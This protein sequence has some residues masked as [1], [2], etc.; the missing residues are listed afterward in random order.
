[1]KRVSDNK[2]WNMGIVQ[3]HV[4][5][6]LIPLIK[7]K[8][9]RNGTKIMLKLNCVGIGRHKSWTFMNLK[10]PFLIRG[11]QRSYCYSWGISTWLSRRQEQLWLALRL[12]QFGTLSAEVG[13]TTSENLKSIILGLGTY[14]FPYNALSKTNRGAPQNEEAAR[15]KIK[16]LRC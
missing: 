15:F 13:S 9:M 10:W 6:R 4:D 3:V 11:S 7:S 1:M 12:R 8:I 2:K 14:V 5:S 16:M